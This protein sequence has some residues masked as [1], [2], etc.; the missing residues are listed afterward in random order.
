MN[1]AFKLKVV[2]WYCIIFYLLLAFKLLNGML[3][4]QLQPVFFFVRPDISSWI[5]MQT[6]LHQ[7]VFGNKAAWILADII[8]YSLP[9]FYLFVLLFRQKYALSTAILMVILN[10]VYIECYALYP[11]VLIQYHTAW[12]FFPLVLLSSRPQTFSLLFDGLRY[13]FVFLFFSA[14][15][16]KI[17]MGGVFNTEQMSGVLLGQHSAQLANSPEYWQSRFYLWMIR[18]TWVSY[19]TYVAACMLQL[20]FIVGFF[21][22][23]YDRWLAAGFV[24]FLV[25]DYLMMRIPY[26]EIAPLVLTLLLKEKPLHPARELPAVADHSAHPSS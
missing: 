26:F 18:H 15:V 24:L 21:S 23:R 13:F 5:F 11:I 4:F 19:L 20:S 14:G 9:L 12:L 17:A 7:W 3:L 22:K 10:W 16:W 6:G 25:C 8:F 2:I 1:S